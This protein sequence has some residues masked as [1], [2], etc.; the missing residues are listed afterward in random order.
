M[1]D[2]IQRPERNLRYGRLWL[3]L[4]W[5][6]AAIIVYLSLVPSAPSLPVEGGDKLEHFAAY[7]LLMLW[8]VQL[9]RNGSRLAFALGFVAMGVGLEFVQELTPTRTFE[10]RDMLADAVGVVV[11]WMLGYT[12]MAEVL[13]HFETWLGRFER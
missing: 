9:Y 2:I 1:A 10:V 11:A 8:F 12:P 13:H 4:G 6:W 5:G 3:L 7:A